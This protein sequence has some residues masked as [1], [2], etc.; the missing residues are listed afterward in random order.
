VEPEATEG[1]FTEW[2]LSSAVAAELN[3]IAEDLI[4]LRDSVPPLENNVK[5]WLTEDIER[6]ERIPY[7]DLHR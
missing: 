4:M 6:I 1:R 5:R 7:P 2:V 3:E